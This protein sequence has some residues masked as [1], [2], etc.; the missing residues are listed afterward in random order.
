MALTIPSETITEVLQRT[1]L[2]ELI[3]RHVVLKRA[4]KSWKG[5]CPFH[6]EKSAS[7]TVDGERWR[8]FGCNAH[9]DA[10]EWLK[11]KE[12]LP[13]L[14]AIRRL[15]AA[16]GIPLPSVTT[17]EPTSDPTAKVLQLASDHFTAALAAP[18]G[19]PARDY[20]ASR[21]LSAETIAELG[22]GW[23]PDAWT[24]LTDKLAR[25]GFLSAAK[26]LG[27][28][29]ARQGSGGHYDLFRGRVIFPIR[30]HSGALLAFSGRYLG[31]TPAPK[32]LNSPE[33]ARY[34]KAS[35]LYGLDL[36]RQ[37][38]RRTRTAILVEGNFDFAALWQ[39]GVKNVVALCS[40]AL[41]GEHLALLRRCDVTE[42]VL[43]LDGDK[44]GQAAITQHARLILPS[45]FATRVAH[46]PFGD[47]PDTF[48]RREGRAGVEALISAA[49]PF[50][51]VFLE[52]L[53]PRGAQ[54][55]FEQKLRGR[56]ALATFLERLEGGFWRSAFLA[57]AARHFGVPAE[58]LLPTP[59]SSG[60]RRA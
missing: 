56:Q 25:L 47:D 40:T 11:R 1:D 29:V 39:A 46:L 35:T 50:S 59:P 20:L 23:A 58:D 24:T 30:S 45:G 52:R 41:T 32:Y 54:A 27:L 49:T 2:V 18:A 33:S 17:R 7:F 42:L 26:A 60:P 4:G 21:G 37:D 44:A 16:A 34:K 19:A 48:A 6:E 55:P 14:D 15:A 53:L 8:C 38:L 43:L 5:L 36:A 28:S 57:E 3:S 12:G 10:L 13:F 22:I 51:A 9:G 31:T